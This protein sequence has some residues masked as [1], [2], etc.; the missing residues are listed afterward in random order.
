M[1]RDEI[2]KTIFIFLSTWL[3]ITSDLQ[4]ST[5]IANQLPGHLVSTQIRTIGL[6]CFKFIIE[7]IVS[8][9]K[10]VQITE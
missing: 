5:A 2:L 10:I 7:S 6:N 9:T 8:S 4:P 3:L 1:W